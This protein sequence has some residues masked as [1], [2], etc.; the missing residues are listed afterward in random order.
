MIKLTNKMG[1][2]VYYSLTHQ[3]LNVITT[4]QLPY[5]TIVFALFAEYS[6]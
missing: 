2:L 5:A 4:G 6:A 1:V 3:F